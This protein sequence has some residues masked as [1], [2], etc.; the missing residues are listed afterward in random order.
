MTAAAESPAARPASDEALVTCDK[1]V[2]GHGSRPLLPPID[3]TI[4]RGRLLA[5]VGRNGS[6]KST[7]FRTVLGFSRPLSGRIER[8]GPRLRM[9]YMAQAN[10]LDPALPVRAKDVVRWGLLGGWGFLR[11]FGGGTRA[12]AVAA[13]DAVGGARFADVLFRDLSEGQKQRVLL[14][15]V[16]ATG[17]DLAFLDE[18]TSAMDAVVERETMER[19]KWLTRERNVGVVVVSHIMGLVERYADEVLYFDRDDASV[20]KGDAKTVFNHPLFLRQ[21]GEL[22]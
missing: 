9:A 5:V 8:A 10:S 22:G 3:V 11:P 7:W 2:I 1:L 13:L 4:R 21:Y 6:G 14:A 19:L 15:R 17:A 18:P 16:L 12:S 20:L